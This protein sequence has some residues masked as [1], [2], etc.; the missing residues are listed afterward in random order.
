MYR[1]PAFL[2]Q[3]CMRKSVKGFASQ[4]TCPCAIRYVSSISAV[5]WRTLLKS[6][7]IESPLD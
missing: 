7:C 2:S 6:V 1:V 3:E 4:Q 5:C